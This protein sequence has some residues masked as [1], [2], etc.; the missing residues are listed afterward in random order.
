LAIHFFWRCSASSIFLF[1]FQRAGL[2]QKAQ[3]WKLKNKNIDFIT[4]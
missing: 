4:I 1:I 3:G 2:E